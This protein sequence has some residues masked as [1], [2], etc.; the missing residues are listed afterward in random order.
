MNLDVESHPFTPYIPKNAIL[1]MLGTFPP[2]TEK[3]SMNFY[4]PNWI[5]DMWRI[6]GIVFYDNKDLFCDVANKTFRLNE[7]QAF[8]NEKGIALHD[9]AS[10]VIRLKDNAADKFLEIVTPIDL[11]NMLKANSLISTIVTTGEKAASVIS[12]LTDGEIPKTGE[13]KVFTFEGRKIKHYRMPSSSRAYPL[14]LQKKAEIYGE[15]F[16]SLD[17]EIFKKNI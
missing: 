4:Y 8:L 2:K 3:W 17:Y 10:E 7:I 13:F 1:L 11:D 6:M 14:S 16:N 9:T 12:Y 5:N 15:M